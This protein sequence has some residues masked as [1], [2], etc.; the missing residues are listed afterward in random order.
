LSA[1]LLAKIIMIGIMDVGVE[2]R[3]K[4]ELVIKG[5]RKNS[6]LDRTTEYLGCEDSYANLY[7]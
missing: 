3:R 7:M 1:Y 5:P 2:C 4:V 6:H